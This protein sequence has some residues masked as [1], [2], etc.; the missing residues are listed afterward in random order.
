MPPSTLWLNFYGVLVEFTSDDAETSEFIESDFSFFRIV[1]PIE[2][3]GPVFRISVHLKPPPYHRIPDNTVATAH[4][5][6]AVVYKTE[7]ATYYDSFGE[8]LVIYTG[9]HD[10]AEI[11]SLDR[12]LLFEKSYLMIMTHVGER[13]DRRGLHRIHAMG[14]VY[15]NKGI[16]C[17]LPMGGGKTTLTLGLLK[18]KAFSLLS[19]EIPLVSTRGMLLT[20]PIRMGVTQGTPLSIPDR[21][22]KDF[23][24][25]HYKA[26]TLI[27]TRFLEGQIGSVVEPGVI[28]V[29]RRLFSAHPRIEKASRLRAF[30]SLFR[31]C[32]MAIGIPQL[33][34]YLLHFDILDAVR[35]S[36]IFVSRLM[37]SLALV[38]KSRTYVLYL[39]YD[40]DENARYVTEFLSEIL[41]DKVEAGG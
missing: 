36:P 12:N 32:V 21:F 6:D 4:T 14:V 34:E 16:L 18:N 10:S 23:K 28:F 22:L 15:R 1:S 27:D 35:Q 38:L 9:G 13:L 37:S 19:E 20:F 40:R 17:L 3:T 26:K 41:E 25:S 24:R 2:N 8:A 7:S 29:G 31:L 33:L 11:Y 30:A 5:K 39:G